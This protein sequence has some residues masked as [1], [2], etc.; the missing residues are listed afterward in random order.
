[1]FL[2]LLDAIERSRFRDFP[3]GWAASGMLPSLNPHRTESGADF[4]LYKSFTGL[5]I[6]KVEAL[7]V[8]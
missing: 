8:L 4:R 5:F 1:M 3:A 7:V 2:A 6:S